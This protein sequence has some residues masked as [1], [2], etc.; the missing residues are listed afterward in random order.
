MNRDLVRWTLHPF[1]YSLGCFGGGNSLQQPIH[2]WLCTDWSNFISLKVRLTNCNSME[3]RLNIGV[4]LFFGEVPSCN[5]HMRSFR[6]LQLHP[7]QS[8]VSGNSWWSKLEGK[9]SKQGG[10]TASIKERGAALLIQRH[11]FLNSL[12]S[13]HLF[14]SGMRL[15]ICYTDSFLHY[16]GGSILPGSADVYQGP[17]LISGSTA[18]FFIFSRRFPSATSS[19]PRAQTDLLKYALWV[20]T[21]C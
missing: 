17:A 9:T 5:I 13:S 8:F 19:A 3:L 4:I 6:I 18:Q 2:Y 10:I 16:A 1:Y 7:L 20:M 12:N 15:L 21:V 11:V 14:S